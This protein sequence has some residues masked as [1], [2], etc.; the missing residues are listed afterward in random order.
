[1]EFT[2]KEKSDGKNEFDALELKN[3]LQAITEACIEGNI[4]VCEETIQGFMVK[5]SDLTKKDVIAAFK[6]ANGRH[7]IHF[8]ALQS[9][10]PFLEYVVEIWNDGLLLPDNDGVYPLFL[11]CQNGNEEIVRYLLGIEGQISLL[12]PSK[13]SPTPFHYASGSGHVPILSLLCSHSSS[14]LDMIAP[15]SGSPLHWAAGEGEVEVISF[16]LSHHCSPHSTNSQGLTPPVLCAAR[17][18]DEGVVLMLHAGAD[19]LVTLPGGIT[20]FH[21][22]CEIGL[23]GSVE[24][25]LSSPPSETSREEW[26]SQLDIPTNEGQYPLD[27]AFSNTHGEEIQKLLKEHSLANMNTNSTQQET[28]GDNEE[29]P[30]KR[31]IRPY[32]P[33]DEEEKVAMERKESGNR[34]FGEKLYVEAITE[35][36]IAIEST[37]FHHVLYS[38]RSACYLATRDLGAALRDA[39]KCRDLA[40]E[41]PKS[42]FR[43]A[44]V[45]FDMGEYEEAAV[46]AWEGYMK[47]PTQDPESE[48]KLLFD[49]AIKK[50][51]KQFKNK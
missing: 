23:L 25:I 36:S 15:T 3:A 21:M 45:L 39:K 1:M 31:E 29:K 34:Y 18:C 51:K 20:L 49:R 41:W 38:N 27:L 43:L 33:T 16:L 47:L 44:K 35:Y 22:C 30:S 11:S 32:K 8:A 26:T 48:L 19:P 50:G 5:H 40:P 4:G 10:L 14:C 24:T 46:V 12:S 42:S 13:P 37:P 9:S 7:V 17:G 6:D 28:K 2:T